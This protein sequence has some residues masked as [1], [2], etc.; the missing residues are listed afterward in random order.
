MPEIVF[1]LGDV[2]QARNDNHLRL[3]R[4]F[5]GAGWR[6]TELPHDCVR[7]A[8]GHLRFAG[9]DPARFD[10]VWP[11][12]FGR[13]SSF[14]DRMQ[15]L[16]QLDQRRL[17]NSADTLVYLHGKYHWLKLMPETHAGNDVA[18]L[19]RIIASGGDWV[20]KPPAGSYGRDVQ[21][22]REGEDPTAAL[23]SL[24][25]DDEALY[26]I[27]QRYVPEI[28][29]GET[30]TIVAGGRIIGS[31]L[32]VPRDELRANLAASATP[33]PA[34]L[35]ATEL[36]LVRQLAGE[37]Q[38]AG[39]GFAAVDTAHG[40]LMEVNIANPGGLATLESLY[41]EDPTPATVAAVIA[42]KTS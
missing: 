7:V 19:A 34:T 37:L 13:Q 25:A 14:L 16:R 23:R 40:F 5:H 17:V 29:Q 42:S 2:A 10:L 36:A 28:R 20:L 6:V 22:L 8:A 11:L 38:E 27:V 39:A 15:L 41:G 3:P 30:R 4:G 21:L 24:T 33:Q 35:S 18:E 26:C 31:Y 12:G 1:L 9:L 32:R